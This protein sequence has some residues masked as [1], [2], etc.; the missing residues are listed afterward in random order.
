M[1]GGR[2]HVNDKELYF[3]LG[4]WQRHAHAESC[5]MWGHGHQLVPGLI[6][7]KPFDLRRV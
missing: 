4:T 5:L 1:G 3:A 7:Q 2:L 6:E